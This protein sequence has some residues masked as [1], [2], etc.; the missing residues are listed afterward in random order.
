MLSKDCSLQTMSKYILGAVFLGLSTVFVV[1]GFT[2]FPIFGFLLALP[3]A[4]LALYFFK[5]RL[6]D[7]CE[8]NI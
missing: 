8:L 1:L 6:N 4:G 7:Q 5:T 3:L 2:L